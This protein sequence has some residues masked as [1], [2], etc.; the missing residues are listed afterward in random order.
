MRL[1]ISSFCFAFFLARA[2]WALLSCSRFVVSVSGQSVDLV[3]IHLWIDLVIERVSVAG[4]A[5]LNS[6]FSSLAWAL[7][8]LNSSMLSALVGCWCSL[9]HLILLARGYAQVRTVSK[10]VQFRD[11]PTGLFR[12]VRCQLLGGM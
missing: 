8:A 10:S 9:C 11:S 2:A 6:V 1:V 7:S 12:L 5:S 4:S 3:V